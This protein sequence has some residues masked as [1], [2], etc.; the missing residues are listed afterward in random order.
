VEVEAVAEAEAEAESY[1]WTEE[2]EQ[3]EEEL[4]SS[5][6]SLKAVRNNGMYEKGRN[7][8]C[9]WQSPNRRTST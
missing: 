7:G 4:Q 2:G 5:S 3:G 9:R 1:A 8:R 6:G